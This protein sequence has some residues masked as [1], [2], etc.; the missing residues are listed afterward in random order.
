MKGF[1]MWILFLVF[2]TSLL[3]LSLSS[4]QDSDL[5]HHKNII[6][7]TKPNR[8][9]KEVI[10]NESGNGNIDVDDYLPSD[11]APSSKAAIRPGPIEHG[12]PLMPYIPKPAPPSPGPYEANNAVTKGL[13]VKAKENVLGLEIVRDESVG[14]QVYHGFCTRPG[15]SSISVG[16]LDG[17]DRGL[18]T[19]VQVFMDFDYAMGRSIIV[20]G[21][22]ITGYGLMI[23][24]CAR[25]W[26]AMM[27]HMIALSATEAEYMTL[28]EAIKENEI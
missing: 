18:Q 13:L 22:S 16:M 21:R 28:A 17:F 10:D 15:I 4:V 14:S 7:L 8:K 27:S 12:A 9:L 26:E 23:Q 5:A 24:G 6:Q 25:S 1:G 2:G 3:C 20:M 11:P 19:H